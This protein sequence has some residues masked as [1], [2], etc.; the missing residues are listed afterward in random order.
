MNTLRN[1]E[2]FT[3]PV[4]EIYVKP[5]DGEIKTLSIN[6]RDIV[7]RIYE[8]ISEKYPYAFNTLKELYSR[9]EKNRIN[10]EYKIVHRFIRCNFGE[11]DTQSY[12]IDN[13]GRFCFE[14]VKCP[15]R[16][17][18]PHECIVCKPTINTSLTERETEIFKL[19]GD[20]LHAQDIAEELK[21]SVATVNRHRENIKYKLKLDTVPQ[22]VK[23]FH[24]NIR[25]H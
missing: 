25:T 12:D 19:I 21:I 14:E 22:M 7:E 5:L 17:E 2:F 23:Y 13:N 4:G 18:C 3:S 8:T 11:Y 20:C 10:F 6:D 16:G 15:V 1:L 9:Y 24:E